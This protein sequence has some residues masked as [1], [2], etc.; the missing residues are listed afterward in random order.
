MEGVAEVSKGVRAQ[1]GI[2]IPTIS[3]ILLVV[4]ND[5]DYR[6]ATENAIQIAAGKNPKIYLL[7]AVDME[8]PPV[9]PENTEKQIY[10]RLRKEGEQVIEECIRKIKASGI[11]VEV[12]GMHFGFAAE[13]ILRTERELKPDLIVLSCR[14]LST[15]KRF[16]LGSISDEVVK[17]A[18]APVLLV[19]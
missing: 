8:L 4:R 14:G 6:K 18:K 17:E 16:L 1:Q 13:R 3:K 7:Y 11:D 12:I 19:K 15:L 10:D 2:M 5:A 9:V